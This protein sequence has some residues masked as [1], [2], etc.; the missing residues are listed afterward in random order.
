MAHCGLCL[1]PSRHDCVTRPTASE[2]SEQLAEHA[3]GQL[4]VHRA[5]T[6]GQGLLHSITAQGAVPE[7]T[8]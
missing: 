2:V 4:A 6:L 5:S 8:L 1:V 7:N 3:G